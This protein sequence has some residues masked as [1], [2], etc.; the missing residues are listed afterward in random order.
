MIF[1][2]IF[3][4][5]IEKIPIIKQFNKARRNNIWNIRRIHN[6]LCNTCNNQ[7]IR[8]NDRRKSSDKNNWRII[9]M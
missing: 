6:N 1:I 7:F 9:Y 3:A 2:K 4:S 5:I 8:T